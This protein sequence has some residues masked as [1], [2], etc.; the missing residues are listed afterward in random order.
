MN[1]L[2]NALD[3]LE[4]S[5]ELEKKTDSNPQIQISTEITGLDKVTIRIADNGMGIASDIKG[6]LFDPFF[7]TK[8]V[9]KG[10]GM[11]LSISYQIITQR[12]GGSIECISQPG[13]GST[14]II[15][16]PLRQE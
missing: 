3:T 15:S 14:W 1:I 11:G 12:H 4:E 13:E 7:T 2:A 8:S 16:I 6:K 5:I 10:T 9:G